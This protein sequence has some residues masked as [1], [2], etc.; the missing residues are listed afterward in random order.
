MRTI[1]LING[2]ILTFAVSVAQQ[3]APT[4][5][6]TGATP[7]APKKQTAQP[8]TK[9]AAPKVGTFTAKGEGVKFFSRGEG[10]LTLK[11]HGF[12]LVGD[13]QGE[14]SAQGFR[15]LKELPRNV[16]LK[17]PMDK[18]IRIFHG[19]GTLTIKGKYDS[20]KVA[21]TEAEINFRGNAS[22][23][24][25]GTGKGLIDGSKEVILY[26]TAAVSL[27]APVPDWMKQMQ[28]SDTEPL[29]VPKA[30]PATPVKPNTNK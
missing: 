10:T 30:K 2:L 15:E 1:A 3:P 16:K 18:R 7:T 9:N 20:V 21:M 5:K 17:P 12:I 27:F 14:I 26:P 13:L 22:F 23:E 19:R 6:E 28:G 24:I 8:N 25:M 11:G 4:Q 29:P